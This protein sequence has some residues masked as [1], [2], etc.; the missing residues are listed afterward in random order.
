MLY[1][2]YQ[3]NGTNNYRN[4][5]PGSA[6][7]DGVATITLDVSDLYQGVVYQDEFFAGA[8][9]EVTVSIVQSSSCFSD[10]PT[11]F[12]PTLTTD[13][14][15]AVTLGQL[16]VT[17]VPGAAVLNDFSCY[18]IRRQGPAGEPDFHKAWRDPALHSDATYRV[19]HDNRLAPGDVSA[20]LHRYRALLDGGA[21]IDANDDFGNAI[22]TGD[23]DGDGL[24]D[25]AIG[26]RGDDGGLGSV[27][28]FKGVFGFDDT[29]YVEHL[30]WMRLDGFEVWAL[31]TGNLD[32][33]SDG[34][35]GTGIDELIIGHRGYGAPASNTGQVTVLGTAI[36][37]STQTGYL[38]RR[39]DISLVQGVAGS[40]PA[41]HWP[42]ANGQ[43]EFGRALDV[44]D[45]NGDGV[46]DI[47]I[48]APG[49]DMTHFDPAVHMPL[50]SGTSVPG[51][52]PVHNSETGSV[53]IL[54]GDLTSMDYVA[55][56]GAVLDPYLHL[57]P[58]GSSVVVKGSHHGS[59]YGAAVLFADDNFAAEDYLVVGAP[60]AFRRVN[61]GTFH[62]PDFETEGD[63]LTSRPPIRTGAIWTYSWSGSSYRY[64]ARHSSDEPNSEF[65]AALA[66]GVGWLWVGAPASRV[67]AQGAQSGAAYKYLITEATQTES[68]PSFYTAPSGKIA[69]NDFP[70]TCVPMDGDGFGA[71]L[72]HGNLDTDAYLAVGAPGRNITCSS[73]VPAGAGEG[74]AYLWPHDPHGTRI[75]VEGA[76]AGSALGDD[77]GSALAFLPHGTY[78][79]SGGTG[80]PT[81]ASQYP[82]GQLELL[83]GA[84]NAVDS[85]VTAGVVL[86]VEYDGSTTFTR[87]LSQE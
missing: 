84:P 76:L 15:V 52:W 64:R 56:S 82:S 35:D 32:N 55:T 39:V 7:F 40:G 31:A 78:S 12:V 45:A 27:F 73:F 18:D 34:V 4:N 68:A 11:E 80:M 60:Q 83:V 48:G 51:S 65:G 81:T 53:F 46:P 19:D 36:N 42:V 50:P 69:I 28:V 41:P 58:S 74:G 75:T 59:R 22:A 24:Q 3:G 1:R 9:F 2:S 67:G 17:T 49:A 26:A 29:G 44:G 71:V 43:D 33:D 14:E 30:P 57:T 87:E 20:V 5:G 85:F 21:P 16:G 25:I 79:L 47:A 66:S 6:S 62:M 23:F 54:L 8:D 72:A 37:A 70:G 86:G 61:Y 38:Q 13:L 77:L 63:H 10:A